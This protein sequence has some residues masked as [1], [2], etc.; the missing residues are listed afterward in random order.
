MKRITKH[1]LLLC[2][3]LASFVL[4]AGC[5]KEN[6]DGCLRC[7]NFEY[8]ADGNTDV[9]PDYIERVSLYVFDKDDK[10]VSA[11]DLG[12]SNPIILEQ[13]D[14]KEY[15]GVKLMITGG[16]YRFVALGNPNLEQA[17]EVHNVE[18]GNMAD[19]FCSH[20]HCT[21]TEVEGND[22]LYLGSTLVEIPDD[23]NYETTLRLYS[24]H[25]KVTVTVKGYIGEEVQG[26]S[27]MATAGDLELRLV[28]LK[29][30]VDFYHDEAG[31]KDQNLALG[32]LV[33]YNP[34]IALDRETGWYEAKFNIL[35]HTADCT[36]A[37]VITERATGRVIATV[38]LAKFLE[39]FYEVDIT[40]QEALIPLILE[41]T[42]EVVVT[43]P[44]W[45]LEHRNPI[46][47]KNY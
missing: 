8:Y 21:S 34:T 29:S 37:F 1:T 23:T 28:D 36:M 43:I 6:L 24:A 10:M 27:A 41:I 16:T 22:P 44:S 35:R 14:L 45:M 32:D 33:A 19:I 47:D 17:T 11:S 15:Q 9:F 13:N 20:P 26:K 39:E 5:I 12:R 2:L 18:C 31:V 38:S 3:S 30:K 42:D 40:K 7:I 4:L 25:Q 46:Y